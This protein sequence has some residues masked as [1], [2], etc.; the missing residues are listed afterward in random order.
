[1]QKETSFHY[2]MDKHDVYI[3]DLDRRVIEYFHYERITPP[4]L[5][6][7]ITALAERKELDKNEPGPSA[8]QNSASDA[9]ALRI[10][11]KVRIIYITIPLRLP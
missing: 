10:V 4:T 1:M 9:R 2:F 7:I 8:V 11:A 6:C 3:S 5:F